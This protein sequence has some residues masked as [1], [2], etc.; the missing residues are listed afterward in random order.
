MTTTSL[1]EVSHWRQLAV[2]WCTCRVEA[3]STTSIMRTKYWPIHVHIR[4]LHGYRYLNLGWRYCDIGM[5]L[6]WSKYNIIIIDSLQ[7][8]QTVYWCVKL[9]ID[10]SN[11]LQMCWNIAK[12]AVISAN[13]YNITR[14]SLLTITINSNKLMFHHLKTMHYIHKLSYCNYMR[15]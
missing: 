11:C 1:S 6:F 13:Y 10:V 4:Y 7:M 12:P 9:S 2:Y 5:Q 3:S 15:K 8:R 14:L